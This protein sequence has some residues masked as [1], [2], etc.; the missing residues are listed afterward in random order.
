MEL[1]LAEWGAEIVF[2]ITTIILGTLA[3][4]F[5][6][7]AIKHKN[8]LKQEREAKANEWIEGKLD[9]IWHELEELRAY[10][11]KAERLE[12]TRMALIISSYKFR[13]VQLCK[14]ILAKGFMTQRE[15]DQL[16]EFYK[17]YVGLGGN[18]QAKEYYEKTIQL[19][20]RPED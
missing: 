10:V 13:L 14:G 6:A 9:P 2:G 15:Y 1:F 11:R 19:D 8:R 17:L 18:G 20:I 3:T 16:T 5:K 4:I 12:E 7:Q